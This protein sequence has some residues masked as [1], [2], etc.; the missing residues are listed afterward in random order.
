MEKASI[1]KAT[2]KVLYLHIIEL[3]FLRGMRTQEAHP[4]IKGL[5]TKTW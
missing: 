2:V 1:L 3:L 5:S 4:T